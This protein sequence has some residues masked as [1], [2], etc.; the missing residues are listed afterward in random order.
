MD[1]RHFLA[2]CL[3]TCVAGAGHAE[4]ASLEALSAYLNGIRAAEAGFTQLN[5]DGSR[6]TGTVY[7]HRPGRIR[8]E[9][10]PPQEDVLVLASGGQVAVF[11]GRASGRPEQY[12]LRRTPLSIL[13]DRNI[14]LTRVSMVT[15][16]GEQNGRTIVQA[17]DPEHP[18]Y[19][20]IYMYFERSPLRLSEWLIVSESGEQTRVRLEPFQTRR[21]FSN[22]LFDIRYETRQRD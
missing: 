10:D 9:Y 19:G 13:L 20:R 16:H 2:V 11:D 4:P 14:D 18:E 21:D 7:I 5:A 6:S 1:R 17:Q 15:G 12:P 3:G 8:F 22:F